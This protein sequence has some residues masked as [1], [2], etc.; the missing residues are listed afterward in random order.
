[1]L[2]RSVTRYGFP[3]SFTDCDLFLQNRGT[4]VEYPVVTDLG[5]NNFY[6]WRQGGSMRISVI[7]RFS[8]FF[9][10][11]F[12]KF[13]KFYFKID[14]LSSSGLSSGDISI[15]T[16]LF[17]Y[18]ASINFVFSFSISLQ[19][20]ST[21]KYCFSS[22]ASKDSTLYS[23]YSDTFNLSDLYTFNLFDLSFDSGGNLLFKRNNSIITLTPSVFFF[24]YCGCSGSIISASQSSLA[25]LQDYY[26]FL[27]GCYSV[28]LSNSYNLYFSQFQFG[29]I[30]DENFEKKSLPYVSD[31]GQ[32]F[33]G[34]DDWKYFSVMLHRAIDNL[35]Q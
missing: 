24:G 1:M 19:S 32:V 31:S 9:N 22:R 18:S 34:S 17:N 5:E 10:F 29:D 28:V 2:I 33:Y 4:F 25:I 21:F 16:L 7:P 15:F 6:Y 14:D 8:R 23:I 13:I 35:S 3:L 20:S 27:L 11:T 30:F 12:D 26:Y